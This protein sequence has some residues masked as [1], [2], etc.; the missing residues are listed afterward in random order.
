MSNLSNKVLLITSR[1]DKGDLNKYS[2]AEILEN[3]EDFSGGKAKKRSKEIFDEFS[4]GEFKDEDEFGKLELMVG[5]LFR[6]GNFIGNSSCYGS[7][8]YK[9]EET[10][11]E[12]IIVIAVII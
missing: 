9:I 4:K 7:F 10:D 5:S 8:E 6:T 1:I 11:F 2:L 12:Y 3:D